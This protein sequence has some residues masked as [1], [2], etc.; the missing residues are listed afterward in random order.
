MA[1]AHC[2]RLRGTRDGTRIHRRAQRHSRKRLQGGPKSCNCV[3]SP[4][5][6]QVVEAGTHPQPQAL[7][8]RARLR[9]RIS[10]CRILPESTRA[11]G[12]SA[13]HAAERPARTPTGADLLLQSRL[14]RGVAR[15]DARCASPFGD[16]LPD[17]RKL[18]A[19]LRERIPISSRSS[20]NGE[21]AFPILR[22]RR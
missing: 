2:L 15:R 21:A 5:D 8:R 6:A 11:D 17:G 16:Q 19:R 12:G 1:I 9:G 4:D 7:S 18:S 13:Q 20:P 3:A 22:I 10:P 14:L